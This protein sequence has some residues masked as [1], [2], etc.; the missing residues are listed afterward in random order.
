MI[1]LR[2]THPDLHRPFRVPGYPVTPVL[3]IAVCIYILSGLRRER[4]G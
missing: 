4:P 3:T 1:V 2:I